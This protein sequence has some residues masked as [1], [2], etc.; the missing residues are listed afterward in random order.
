VRP[1]VLAV[2]LLL[3]AACSGGGGEEGAGTTTSTPATGAIDWRHPEPLDAG[4]GWRLDDCEGDA[5]I[6]CV[7]RDGEPAGFLEVVEFPVASFDVM[8]EPLA[9][10]DDDAALD[11]LASSFGTDLAADRSLGCGE[12]YVVDPLPVTHLTT[13][14]G[15]AVRYGLVGTTAGGEVSERVVQYAAIRGDSLVVLVAAAYDADG[16]LVAE[17]EEFAPD[18]LEAFQPVLDRVVAASPMP[19]PTASAPPA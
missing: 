2:A 16:C 3:A 1:T 10:G 9:D 6:V 4:D 17:G 14:D 13:G 7:D 5:P 19:A 15:P 8:A 12:G 18:V 11:A